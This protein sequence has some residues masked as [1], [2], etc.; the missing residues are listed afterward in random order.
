[1][2]DIS[3][4]ASQLEQLQRDLALAKHRRTATVSAHEC[5][6]CGEPIPELRRKTIIGCRRCVTC[7]EIVEKREKGYR[8]C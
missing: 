4:R 7:Q 5:D 3:D 2:S 1:M 8:Q 6:D